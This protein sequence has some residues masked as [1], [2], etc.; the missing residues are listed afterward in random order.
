[1]LIAVSNPALSSFNY[2]IQRLQRAQ[3]IQHILHGNIV[4]YIEL[5]FKQFRETLGR[6]SVFAVAPDETGR[7]V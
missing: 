3:S 1:M 6:W 4:P 2:E 5:R 7:R